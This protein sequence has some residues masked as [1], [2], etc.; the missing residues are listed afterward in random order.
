MLLTLN[1]IFVA[2]ALWL[3]DGNCWSMPKELP[4]DIKDEVRKEVKIWKEEN[5]PP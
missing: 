2:L 5:E 4:A 1:S 3:V